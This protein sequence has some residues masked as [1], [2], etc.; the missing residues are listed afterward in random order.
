MLI[1]AVVHISTLVPGGE[2]GSGEPGRVTPPEYCTQ[3]AEQGAWWLDWDERWSRL[4]EG[5]EEAMQVEEPD[6]LR[7]GRVNGLLRSVLLI[8]PFSWTT[9]QEPFPSRDAISELSLVDCIKQITRLSRADRTQ[10]G[11]LWGA[12][13]AGVLLEICQVAWKRAGGGPVGTLADLTA[14]T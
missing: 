10:E 12:L 8:Q 2:L 6:E 3:S 9:W 11:I 13:R 1:D 14:E 5:L 4:F 7:V